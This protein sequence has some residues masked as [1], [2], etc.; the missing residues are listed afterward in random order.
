MSSKIPSHPNYCRI[1]GFWD[2]QKGIRKEKDLPCLEARKPPAGDCA[3]LLPP[4]PPMTVYETFT[5]C[6]SVQ[7][8][9]RAFVLQTLTMTAWSHTFS[10]GWPGTRVALCC[11]T[12]PEMCSTA[13][14]YSSLAKLQGKSTGVTL[15]LPLV[16]SRRR[17]CAK[18]L[19]AAHGPAGN[20]IQ[21]GRVQVLCSGQQGWQCLVLPRN[22]LASE[23]LSLP[24]CC[25]RAPNVPSSC[26]SARSSCGFPRELSKQIKR[27]FW[28]VPSMITQGHF[29]D[30]GQTPSQTA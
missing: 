9:P 7:G 10:W 20:Q 5:K 3:S 26:R 22:H 2:L 11:C 23:Q 12:S 6:I 21:A 17:R 18:M 8:V 1:P 24:D 15:G 30:T 4:F 16:S 14:W 28:V 29:P 19:P 27:H 25:S 13:C